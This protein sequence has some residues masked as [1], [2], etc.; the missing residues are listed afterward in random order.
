ML[1]VLEYWLKEGADGF[2][3]DAINHMFETDGLPNEVYVN[4]NEDKSLYD[5]LIHNHTMN[6]VSSM[7]QIL[8][9]DLFIRFISPNPIN[10][11]TT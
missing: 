7:S 9:V 10:S 2:R 8:L 6:L 5:N 11:F 1:D 3:I 4:E